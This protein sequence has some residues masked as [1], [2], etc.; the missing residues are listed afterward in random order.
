MNPQEQEQW[1]KEHLGS[2]DFRDEDALQPNEADYLLAEYAIPTIDDFSTLENLSVPDLISLGFTRRAIEKHL[3][4]AASKWPG[5]EH[6]EPEYVHA[7]PKHRV[8]YKTPAT[9][10][11]LEEVKKAMETPEVKAWLTRTRERRA[12]L[13]KGKQKVITEALGVGIYIQDEFPSTHEHTDAAVYPLMALACKNWNNRFADEI[14]SGKTRKADV[15]SDDPVMQRQVAVVTVRHIRDY[16]S[17]YNDMLRAFKN[18]PALDDTQQILRV[19]AAAEISRHYPPL[20]AAAK[21]VFFHPEG[22][23]PTHVTKL[24]I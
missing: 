11:S 9:Y 4:P 7:E 17:N 22:W 14:Q 1:L 12:K 6:V 5:Y 20:S 18:R 13:D 23:G 3:T 10:Y 24:R 15:R 21:Y 19:K 2:M 8:S 16:M